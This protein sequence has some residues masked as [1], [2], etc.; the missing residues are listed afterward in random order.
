VA[1]KKIVKKSTRCLNCGKAVYHDE[2]G[3]FFDM[4]YTCRTDLKSDDFDLQLFCLM[5]GIDMHKVCIT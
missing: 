1:A 2:K 5:S 4:C 3:P